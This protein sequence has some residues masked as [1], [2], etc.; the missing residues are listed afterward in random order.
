LVDLA[1]MDVAADLGGTVAVL[2]FVFIGGAGW[3]I[4]F[5]GKRL[6]WERGR[7]RPVV[8]DVAGRAAGGRVAAGVG[9]DV[10]GGW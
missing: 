3:R 6:F 5:A 10:E 1:A 7:G 8:G 9:W 4:G 2:G